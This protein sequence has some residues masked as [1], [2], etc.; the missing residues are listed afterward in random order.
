M[1]KKQI[2]EPDLKLLIDFLRLSINPDLEFQAVYEAVM[3]SF[4]VQTRLFKALSDKKNSFVNVRINRKPRKIILKFS[5]LPKSL[6]SDAFAESAENRK[7]ESMAVDAVQTEPMPLYAEQIEPVAVDAVQIESEPLQAESV[8][9]QPVPLQVVK[10][11]SD[12]MPVK[13]KGRGKAKKQ[14]SSRS[15][16]SVLIDDSDIELLGK[17][18]K[19]RDMNLSQ[20]I[21][22][23]VRRLLSSE[24]LS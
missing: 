23:A 18:G 14:S 21:R 8:Q 17:L 16:V 3:A 19:C 24:S 9:I 22:A 12:N 2:P 15:L 4:S 5:A 10:T 1:I 7:F 20:L 13:R 11:D 6:V